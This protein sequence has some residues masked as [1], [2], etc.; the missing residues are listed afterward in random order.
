MLLDLNLPD[1]TGVDSVVSLKAAAPEVPILV[2]ADSDDEDLALRSLRARAEDFVV[3]SHADR[4]ALERAIRRA[5][6]RRCTVAEIEKNEARLRSVVANSTDGMVVV[7]QTGDVL[8]A[9]PA[10]TRLVGATASELLGGMLGYPFAGRSRHE[11][12]VRDE[13]F[14][15][16]HL[17]QC[18]WDGAPVWLASLFDITEHQRSRAHLESDNARIQVANVRLD[19]LASIDPLT[20]VLNRRGLDAELA[21]EIR[22]KHRTGSPLAAVLLDCDDFKRINETLGHAGGDAVLKSIAERL[23][24]SLRPS[25]HLGRV[26]GDE[27][28]ALLPDT[29]FAEAYQVAERLRL[30]V[31]DHPVEFSTGIVRVSASLGI[32]SVDGEIGSI[33][34]LISRTQSSLRCSKRAGKN[35]V[36]TQD[37]R[38]AI[39]ATESDDVL[40]DL[41]LE[42]GFR[43]LRRPIRRLSDEGVIGWEMISRGPPGV[44]EL[45]R[46]FFRL[47]L[48]RHLLTAVD[49]HCLRT[50]IRASESLPRDS[51]CHIALFPSTLLETPI[52]RL[53]SFFI[54]RRND[55]R[56]CVE[57]SEQH[58]VGEPSLLSMH[59][60][61]LKSAGV[62]VTI[63]DVGFGRSSLEPLILLEPDL[64]ALDAGCIRQVSRD[65][66]AERSLRRMIAVVESLGA[67]V[68]ADGIASP[69]DLELLRTL[70]VPFGR[71]ALWG[72]AC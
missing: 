60:R 33:D 50:C 19:R 47:A 44:F 8:F 31:A 2:I 20:Q 42:S 66:G 45:P 29:R 67:E 36:S 11:V 63:R 40:R 53:V 4:G 69:V 1:S 23:A 30:S 37:G 48:E 57:I 58:F 7:S 16:V 51:Q 14:I 10:A 59:V 32:E 17:V 38:V 43:V 70:H 26:G 41:Q 62:L 18:E 61:A 55:L 9:N 25:D 13:R 3:K 35:R 54:G 6:A 39:G 71:G 72:P 27:F 12:V 64:V 22:R 21:I 52:D 56:F 24:D 34:D 65:A 46:D 28:L 15:E 5:L 68:I 49:L